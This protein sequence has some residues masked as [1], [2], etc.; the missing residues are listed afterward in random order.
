MP[1]RWQTYA[2]EFNGGLITNLSPLQ[3]GANA[4]GSARVLRNFEPSIEGGYR[5]I[6]GFDKYDDNLVPPYGAPVVHGSG[7]TGTS[8]VLGNIHTEPED[9]DTFTIAGVSGTYTIDTSGVSYD[10]TNNRATLTLTTSLDSSPTNA[11]AVTFTSTTSNYRING[12]AS[13][14]DSVIVSRNNS[15]FQTTGSGFT[16]INVPDYG[17]V[18]VDGGSQTGTSL[19]V[20]GLTAAPQAGDVF[21]I[22]GVDLVYTVTVDATVSSGGATLSIN[23]A[24]DSS[25]ADNAAITFLSTSRDGTV[26]FRFARYNFD[27]TEKIVM[28]DGTNAPAIYD[29]TTFTVFDDAPI[30]VV[31]ANHV[32]NFKNQLF[33]SKG[34]NL[35][36]TAPF[37]DNDFTAASGAGTINVGNA[38]TGLIIFREQLI[39]FSERRISRLVGSTI[40]DFQLQPVTMDTG[41]IEE[42]TIQEV[43]GDIIFL[44]PDGL[45][46]LATTDKFGDFSIGVISKPI[47]TETNRLISQNTSFA[48]VV[49]REKSQYRILGYNAN[50]TTDAARGILATQ[51]EQGIQWAE[52]RGI[53]AYVADSNY[54][55]STEVVVFGHDDGY[56]YQMESGNSFDGANISAS[57]ATPFIPVND[58]RL[59][60]TF[61]KMFL[62][63]DPQGSFTADVSLKYDF[64]E[65]DVIQPASITFN[66]ASGADALAFYG[67][68]EYGTG[69]YGGTIQR[70]FDSQLIG[71]GFVVSL[72]FSSES[73]NPPYSLDALTFEYGT[74]GRR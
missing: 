1:D 21:K 39:I 56:V 71:S 25:P 40:A 36:F 65:A 74:Y 46:S 22:A 61:Y 14:E 64:E 58:P 44:G 47:Q 50:I 8:L 51:T 67:E 68:A 11:A 13:W 73:T 66:N 41:C 70:L 33:F 42:D 34:S 45:R 12:I 35:S 3:H 2:V 37:T 32:V 38:I 52:L 63:T 4:P 57:F 18:L 28:V 69:E 72:V 62:Y 7:Q 53:R 48:S 9:G 54:N 10:A 23:P 20:D 43:G 59:R 5:R 31:G 17:T 30:D 24:L 27:G 60:K 19:V 49:I 6:E 26:K 55:A 29:D 15:I 16:H